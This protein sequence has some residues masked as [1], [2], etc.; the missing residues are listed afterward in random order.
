M[1]H[2]CRFTEAREGVFSASRSWTDSSFRSCIGVFT[3]PG[4]TVLT[5]VPATAASRASSRVRLRSAALLA[6]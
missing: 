1:A 4:R 2:V 6:A 5:V 3:T